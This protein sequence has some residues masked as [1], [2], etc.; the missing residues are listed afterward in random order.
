[1]YDYYPYWKK[2][3]TQNKTVTPEKVP[4]KV[5]NHILRAKVDDDMHQ[6]VKEDTLKEAELIRKLLSNY[7][8]VKEKIG[9]REDVEHFLRNA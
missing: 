2:R 6:K 9:Q 1:M 8:S 3:E 7:F 5:K 4:P